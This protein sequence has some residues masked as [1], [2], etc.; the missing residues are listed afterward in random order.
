MAGFI[1]LQYASSLS[2]HE[3]CIF[4]LMVLSIAV[5]TFKVMKAIYFP[6]EL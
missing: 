3:S 2:K 1:E 5:G 6:E 4:K